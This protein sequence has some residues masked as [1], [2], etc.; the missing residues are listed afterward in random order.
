[1]IDIWLG[2]VVVMW[3]CACRGRCSGRRFRCSCMNE[4][5]CCGSGCVQC[6]C[7]ACLP[8]FTCRV[9]MLLFAAAAP[10]I[11]SGGGAQ[12][13]PVEP[14]VHHHAGG[15]VPPGGAAHRVW[16]AGGERG[17]PLE[18]RG[19]RAHMQRA[20]DVHGEAAAGS[21]WVVWGDM[22]SSICDN[23]RD[24]IGGSSKGSSTLLA[25]NLCGKTFSQVDARS[26]AADALWRL[27]HTSSQL[28][29]CAAAE[30]NLWI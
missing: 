19:A 24:G 28:R 4:V 8:V 21:Y 25:A 15:A 26:A 12:P 18:P 29:E 1:M 13:V 23:S 27:L 20:Q 17:Q 30:V 7:S 11:S 10:C 16:R 9:L 3:M 2:C 14:R 22:G 5:A 6:L